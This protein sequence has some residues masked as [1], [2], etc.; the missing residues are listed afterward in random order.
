[1]PATTKPL[2]Q[3]NAQ[4][5]YEVSSADL[6]LARAQPLLLAEATAVLLLAKATIAFALAR[7]AGENRQNALRFGLGDR[8]GPTRSAVETRRIVFSSGISSLRANGFQ[9]QKS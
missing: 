4:N 7:I 8:N 1:M 2:I 9:S 3:P 5:Q 6:P